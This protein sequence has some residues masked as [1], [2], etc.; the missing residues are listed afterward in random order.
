[1]NRKALEARKAEFTDAPPSYVRLCRLESCKDQDLIKII[2][3]LDDKAKERVILDSFAAMGATVTQGMAPSG[4]LE[5]EISAW[6]DVLK[7]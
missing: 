2:F 1:M 4:Y 3:S 5:E 6:I 7:S